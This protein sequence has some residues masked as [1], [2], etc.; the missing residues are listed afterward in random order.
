VPIRTRTQQRGEGWGEFDAL[1]PRGGDRKAARLRHG[2]GRHGY[3]PGR[4][5]ANILAGPARPRETDGPSQGGAH[6]AMLTGPIDPWPHTEEPPMDAPAAPIA[7]D[8]ETLRALGRRFDALGARAIRLEAR[9]AG[10]LLAAWRPAEPRRYV[11]RL[12]APDLPAL[13]AEARGQ[14]GCPEPDRVAPPRPTP[15]GYQEVLRLL[16]QGL[17]RR[18]ARLVRL[19]EHSDGLIVQSARGDAAGGRVATELVRWADLAAKRRLAVGR[20]RADA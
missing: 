7:P 11:A 5:P 9:R 15:L 3:T 12:A 1:F 20:R 16:G 17:D 8:T 6:R 4:A 2:L 13:L 19:I 18:G 10:L 14:R